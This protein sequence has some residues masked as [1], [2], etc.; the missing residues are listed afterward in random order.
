MEGNLTNNRASSQFD[1]FTQP[2]RLLGIDPAASNTQVQATYAA[3]IVLRPTSQGAALAGARDTIL[4]PAR[5][6]SAE[7]TYP[8]D[9]ATADAETFYAALSA[10]ASMHQLLLAADQLAPLSRANFIVHLAARRPAESAVLQAIVDAHIGI[11]VTEVYAILRTLRAR[12]SCPTPS[13]AN[14]NQGLQDL[15]ALHAEAAFAGYQKTQDAAE[16]VMECTRHVLASGDRHRIEALS[17]LLDV[18]RRSTASLRANAAQQI[19]AACETLRQSPD[20]DSSAVAELTEALPLWASLSGPLMAFDAYQ[21]LQDRDFE[22]P[23]DRVRLLLTDLSVRQHHAT[24]RTVAN[25]ARD[26]F[27]SMPDIV[28][29]FDQASA[30]V[31]VAALETEIKS[32][33]DDNGGSLVKSLEKYGFGSTYKNQANSLWHAFIR[34]VKATDSS[35][36]ADRPWSLTRDFAMHLADH[37]QTARAASQLIAGMIRHGKSVAVE[38]E[39]LDAL[40]DD[41]ND[42]RSRHSIGDE[43]PSPRRRFLGRF[44]KQTLLASVALVAAVGAFVG[45]RSF[46]NAGLQFFARA[47]VSEPETIPPVGKEQHFG[48]DYVR[49][50]HFQEERLR[51]IKQEVHGPEDS[52]AFNALANDYNSRCSDFFYLEDDLKT[53][54]AEVAAKKNELDAEARQIL[55]T[56]PWHAAAGGSAAPSTK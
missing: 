11:E 24:A 20:E 9:T 39:I 40:D 1:L 36:L 43:A 29:Q 47:P 34:A 49:Y 6:L 17:G 26:A 41:L 31:E 2:F 4:D 10:G 23:I 12:A 3:A 8:I 48:L 28:S 15:F 30:L 51:I 32:L 54:M 42:I 46:D 14:V 38:P 53:V 44:G 13:L 19:E 56:W 50:C 18:Y 27:S 45:Y 55:A 22:I 37:K 25:L 52:R 35:E 16:P 21:G 5:R 33:L 7:L